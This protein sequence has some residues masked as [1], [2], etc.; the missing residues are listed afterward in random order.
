M[1]FIESEV[2]LDETLELETHDVK[3]EGDGVVHFGCNTVK[4]SAAKP[5]GEARVRSEAANG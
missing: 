3:D 4:S 1:T 2:I 5:C